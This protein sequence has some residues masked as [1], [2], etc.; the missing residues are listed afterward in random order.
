MRRLGL[1]RA[2]LRKRR[3]SAGPEYS[4][5][6]TEHLFGIR[7][8]MQRVEADDTIDAFRW[9]IYP[10]TVEQQE[11]RRRPA[12]RWRRTLEQFLAKG[13]RCG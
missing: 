9:Q 3:N 12:P 5:E 7:N 4:S 11:S 6:F 8:M 1:V 10:A 2:R 13:E